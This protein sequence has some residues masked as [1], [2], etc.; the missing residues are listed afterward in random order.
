MK[1]LQPIFSV[2]LGLSLGL[3]VTAFAG[4][5]PMNVLAIL[6][7][8]AFGTRYD[9]GM[10]LFYTTPL[11]FTGLSVAI[12]FHAGLFNIGA[13]GQLVMGALAV[14]AVGGLFPNVPAWCAPTLAV[15]ASWVGGGAWGF[16]PGWLRAR[17]GAHEVIN[18]IML[19]FVAAGLASYVTVYLLRNPD[20][21]M[22]ET[23][24]VGEGYRLSHFSFFGGDAPV[25]FAFILALIAALM[26]WLLLWKTVLGYEIRSV[27]EN[28]SAS[29]A[30]GINTAR[31]RILAMAIAGAVAGMV[32][33]GEVLGNAGRFK[34]GF[35]PDY[36]FIGIA[37]A[38]LGRNHPIGVVLAAFL[39]GALHKGTADLDFET[40]NITR[41][42][43]FILQAMVILC[44][45]AVGLWDWSKKR[46]EA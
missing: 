5:S 31:A 21:Q 33:V 32:G 44:V 11:I 39:F 28:E 25:T 1:Y 14:G 36:G 38:L 19:N 26:V 22:A 34:L 20:S 45:S 23:I 10:T 16:I 43:S 7:K 3:L 46:K 30:A 15:I 6:G 35:S 41:D 12:A 18:T 27:G 2:I 40:E 42:V 24:A 37:V 29:R 8:G 9:F 4:E 13:E 17:R